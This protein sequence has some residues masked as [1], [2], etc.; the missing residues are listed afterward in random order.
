[1]FAPLI[2]K[3]ITRNIGDRFT[4]P[5]ALQFFAKMRSQ[6]TEAQL[7]APFS[8]VEDSLIYETRDHWKGLP[9]DFVKQWA[10]YKAPP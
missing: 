9:D 4:A 10:H 5:E 2:D 6:L 7:S 3:M 1:M 8:D